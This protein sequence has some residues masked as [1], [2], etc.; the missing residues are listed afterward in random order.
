MIVTVFGN[1]TFYKTKLPPNPIGN[2]WIED[3]NEKKIISIEGN[4][5]GWEIFSNN[6]AKIINPKNVKSLNVFK[7]A[8]IDENII[9]KITLKEYGIYYVYLQN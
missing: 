1:N 5:I 3:E 9:K 6:Q 4:G 2:Y 7:I 8:Q